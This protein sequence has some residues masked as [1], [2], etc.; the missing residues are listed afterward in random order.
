MM[1]K[2][3]MIPVLVLVAL[4]GAGLWY[5]NSHDKNAPQVLAPASGQAAAPAT[6]VEAQQVETGRSERTIEA[7]GDLAS[8]ESVVLS[9]EISGR[10]VAILFE[11]GR[12]VKAGEPLI[13]LDDVIARAELAQVQSSLTLSKANYERAKKL[14]AE[15]TGTGRARDEAV[16]KLSNDQASYDLAKARLEKTVLSAPFDGVVGLRKVSIGDYVNPGQELVNLE[17]IDPLKVDFRMP[18]IYLSH[19]KIGQTINVAVDSF[20]GQG[21]A[22]EVYAIDPRVD[23][24]GR[25]VVLRAKMPN[26]DGVLRPGL[27]ARVRLLLETNE[28]ALLVP[29]AALFPQG[30]DL[31]VYRV[32][33]GKAERVQ[34]TVGARR[35][36]KA[37]I[38][39][40]LQ[41][42]DIVITA[43][44]MKLRP[45]AP[46]TVLPVAGKAE[47][48]K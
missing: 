44:Q 31:F 1:N 30:N 48:A 33:D 5:K 2:K 32:V 42:S 26:D 47:V 37:E 20:P 23:S 35:T 36:G 9:P 22:G 12:A 34:V 46:V 17:S 6:A 3:R 28:N 15:Q 7:V 25:T 13:R 4:A 8:N 14:Y 10:I 45:N 19:L 40:G 38:L 21:F 18:E 43:G 41:A 16:A 29:E 39:E 27:F 24:N 11:E